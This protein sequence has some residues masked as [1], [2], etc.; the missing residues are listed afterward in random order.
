MC[1]IDT[2]KSGQCSTT[3]KNAGATPTV[4][5]SEPSLLCKCREMARR[6]ARPKKLFT[7]HAAF[8]ENRKDRERKTEIMP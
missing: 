4:P 8:L 5:Q 3:L 1:S 7:L 2:I 6:A